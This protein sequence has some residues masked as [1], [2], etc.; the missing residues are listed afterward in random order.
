MIKTW[1]SNLYLV[2]FDKVE[3]KNL[4]NQIYKAKYLWFP[5]A[6]ALSKIL[7]E[8]IEGLNLNE[9]IW[10][11]NTQWEKYIKEIFDKQSLIKQEIFFITTDNLKSKKEIARLFLKNI[12]KIK[13]TYLFIIWADWDS[14]IIEY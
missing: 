8:E 14:Y 7:R 12:N 10:I 5:K 1:F 6:L 13:D 3:Q 4:L 9:Y 2:D 11:S